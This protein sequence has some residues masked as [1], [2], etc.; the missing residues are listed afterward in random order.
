MTLKTRVTWVAV[1]TVVVLIVITFFTAT[2]FLEAQASGNEIVGKLEPAA[3]S[4]SDLLLSTADMERGVRSYVSTQKAASLGPYAEGS[5][6]S[7]QAVV[8]LHQLLDS[9]DPVLEQQ[10]E[11][12]A[13][14]RIEWIDTVA[15]PTINLVRANQSGAAEALLDSNASLRSFELLRARATALNTQI[16]SRLASQFEAFGDFAEQLG[17]VLLGSGV[18]IIGGLVLLWWLLRRWVLKPLNKLGAQ[19]RNVAGDAG[20]GGDKDTEIIPLGPP[21]IAQVGRDAD[22]MRRR[23]VKEIET[24]DRQKE[25]LINEGPVITALRAEL[26][27][28]PRVYAVGLDIYGEM[29]PSESEIAGDWWDAVSLPDGRTALLITDISGH[30][31]QAGVAGL[32]LKLTLIG[33]LE[34][35]SSL[36]GAFERGVK[37]FAE[38]PGRFATAAAV[39]IDPK[40]HEIEW[41]NAGHL[42]PLVISPDGS[43]RELAITGPL[44]ST[45]GG[46]WTSEKTGVHDDDIVVLW[47]DGVTESRDAAGEQLETSG[48][49]KIIADARVNA[50]VKPIHLVR[51]VLSAGR[52]RAINWGS[53]DRT[54]IIASFDSTDPTD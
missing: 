11:R 19:M 24:V 17:V 50:Q 33:M 6:V 34:S 39:V 42:P 51:K 1:I 14:A 27:R 43:T 53:D 7:E 20:Y 41:I 26:S 28:E 25:S 29:E 47:T 5:T 9:T 21:E 37:L 4:A 35:G 16:D 23:L 36:V 32:R 45:L 3:T 18:A 31:P 2:R 49:C 10:V 30:G 46:T 40:T 12:V 48:L 54:L 13:A 52:S 8:D 15:T 38:T 44:M 22:D